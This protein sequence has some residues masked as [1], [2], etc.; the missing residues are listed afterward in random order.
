MLCRLEPA[1]YLVAELGVADGEVAEKGNGAETV[2]CSTDDCPDP[3]DAVCFWRE[4]Y[5]AFEGAD[6]DDEYSRKLFVRST[7]ASSPLWLRLQMFSRHREELGFSLDVD[8]RAAGTR[9]ARPVLGA[10]APDAESIGPC[11]GGTC[12]VGS[13]RRPLDTSGG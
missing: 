10:V 3:A 5:E 6:T 8:Q 1:P 13:E 4:K 2:R 7:L 12:I 11:A 9:A